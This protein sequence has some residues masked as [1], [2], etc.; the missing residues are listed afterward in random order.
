VLTL[1]SLH[2]FLFE[3]GETQVNSFAG[4]HRIDWDILETV[5]YSKKGKLIIDLDLLNDI[6]VY[7]KFEQ[8]CC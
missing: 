5:R 3:I 4:K 8:G 1:S 7:D 2:Q 6:D